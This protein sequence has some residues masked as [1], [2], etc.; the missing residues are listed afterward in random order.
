VQDSTGIAGFIALVLMVFYPLIRGGA[1][2]GQ[3]PRHAALPVLARVRRLGP[4]QAKQGYPVHLRVVVTYLDATNMFV[5]DATGA[6]RVA[7]PAN[8]PKPRRGRLILLEGITT[9][10]DFAPDIIQPAWREAGKGPALRARR[11]SI[12]QMATSGVDG[13]G[14]CGAILNKK[15][16][17]VVVSL[18]VPT[19]RDVLVTIKGRLS[20]RS[21]LPGEE[22][23]I[24][25]EG[26]TVFHAFAGE[27]FAAGSFSFGDG[28]RLRLTGIGL[29]EKGAAGEPQSFKL[30]FRS[31]DDVA[32][33]K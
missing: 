7:W 11:V 29:I 17:L 21:S 19:M 23:L 18:F 30:H 12:E 4:D 24:L 28:S 20:A 14:I 10:S 32:L 33:E 5:Q 3:P 31:L 27:K 26:N 16:Q 22:L 13:Q 25:H 8:R 1:A 6:I 2:S 9:Q 15:S